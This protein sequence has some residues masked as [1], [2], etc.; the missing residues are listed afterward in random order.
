M[1]ICRSISIISANIYL[2]HS[3]QVKI[4]TRYKLLI[5]DNNRKTGW[6]LHVTGKC[7]IGKNWHKWAGLP[8]IVTFG[9]NDQLSD[10]RMI[11]PIGQI[12]LRLTNRIASFVLF[13]VKYRKS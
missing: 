4:L 8:E 1:N 9:R 13:F 5:L 6:G 10:V 3:C 11:L 12:I 7:R 2:N